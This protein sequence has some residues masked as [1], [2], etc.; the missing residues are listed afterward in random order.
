MLE[1]RV[2]NGVVQG[3][4][5]DHLPRPSEGSVGCS[6][7]EKTQ[8]VTIQHSDRVLIRRPQSTEYTW[9][10]SAHGVGSHPPIIPP[11]LLHGETK[12]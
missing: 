11:P 4:T 1:P 8:L 10:G 12:A 6:E 3:R 5:Q 2:T 9:L 7:V